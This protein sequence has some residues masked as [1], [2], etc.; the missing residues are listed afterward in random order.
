MANKS[1]KHSKNIEGPWYCTDPDDDDGEG[2]IACNVCYTGAPDFFAEDEDGVEKAVILLEGLGY[3]LITSCP[4]DKFF[5][6]I[7]SGA[8]GKS[9]FLKVLAALVGPKSICA[10]QPSQFSNRFQLAHLQSRLVNIITEISKASVLADAELKA[11]VSGELITVEHKMKDPFEIRPYATCWFG[12][13]HLPHTRDFS[14]AMLRRARILQFNNRFVGDKCIPELEKQLIP[15]LPG[16]LNMALKALAGVFERGA[17]T[18]CKSVEEANK[19]WKYEADQVA[20]FASEAC[21]ED[22]KYEVAVSHLYTKF[23]E[24]TTDA[25]IQ[26]TVGRSEFSRRLGELGFKS[27]RIKGGVRTRLGLRPAHYG[28]KR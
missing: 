9:V 18:T 15:E 3:S 20:Q 17:F 26:K 10:V 4:F 25:G 5:M 7:G 11:I 27:S 6:L 23:K 24:W 21:E 8:N 12:M 13:N 1:Q 2:C 19:M 22:P 16:I 28:S 14:F